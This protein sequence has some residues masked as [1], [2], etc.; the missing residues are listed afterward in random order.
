MTALLIQLAMPRLWIPDIP[1]S[2]PGNHPVKGFW[3]WSA[4]RY[5]QDYPDYTYTI[6]GDIRG[7]VHEHYSPLNIPQYATWHE[8]TGSVDIALMCMAGG[9]LD[10]DW[11]VPP[12]MIQVERACY[13]AAKTSHQ[14]AFPVNNWLTHC[15]IATKDG[16]GPGSGD[17]DTRWDLVAIDAAGQRSRDGG[18]VMR[19]KTRWYA[20]R[21]FPGTP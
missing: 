9:E 18:Q 15:E 16:Y 2:I 6:M 5:D 21:Y 13:L 7:T 10:G 3:H 14:F 4:G 1:W 20:D 17:P 19:Q 8:N 12:L 11:P